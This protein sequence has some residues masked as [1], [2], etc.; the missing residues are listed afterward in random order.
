[1]AYFKPYAPSTS[2]NVIAPT[3]GGR[4]SLVID[5]SV[6]TAAIDDPPEGGYLNTYSWDG[7]GTNDYIDTG[8]KPTDLGVN[9]SNSRT[10][11]CWVNWDAITDDDAIWSCGADA[12]E[13]HW[14]LRSRTGD[15]GDGSV[16]YRL[17]LRGTNVDFSVAG[18]EG[19]W[20]H[21]VVVGISAGGMGGNTTWV[22]VN[23]SQVATGEGEF[24]TSNANN[25]VIGRDARTDGNYP[26]AKVDEFSI[27]NAGL[28]SS[29]VTELYNSGAAFDITTHSLAATKLKLLYTFNAGDCTDDSGNESAGTNNGGAFSTTVP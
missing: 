1:M 26:N 22:Y 7:D 16:N 19:N 8:V 27:W 2:R 9:G 3:S 17:D 11:S 10:W 28:N 14:T 23:G 29:Q 4:K 6:A 15:A 20:K 5:S 13:Q 18:S 21:I 24:N 12:S 25:I